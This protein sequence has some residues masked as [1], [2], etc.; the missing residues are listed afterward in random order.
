VSIRS[1]AVRDLGDLRVLATV[2]IE[3]EEPEAVNHVVGDIEVVVDKVLCG[4]AVQALQSE[5]LGVEILVRAGGDPVNIVVVGVADYGLDPV[6]ALGVGDVP[7]SR[8]SVEQ[9]R[10]VLLP[11]GGS[12]IVQALDGGL[13]LAVVTNTEV[14]LAW[15]LVLG[16]CL[17]GLESSD[18]GALVPSEG[19]TESGQGLGSLEGAQVPF[20]NNSKIRSRALDTPQKVGVLGA[21]GLNNTAVGQDDRHALDEIKS[22]AVHVR[23]EPESSVKEVARNTHTKNGQFLQVISRFNVKLTLG[24]YREKWLCC[25]ARRERWQHVL[26]SH[27]AERWR[28]WSSHS[29]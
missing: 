10:D 4:R 13:A 19:H 2:D 22:K 16:I 25:I 23:A 20:C 1:L 21:R 29:K 15:C 8:E 3:L 18:S 6:E 26:I 27:R 28:S 12:T 14:D 11:G 9:R 17:D 5:R 24:R 7:S